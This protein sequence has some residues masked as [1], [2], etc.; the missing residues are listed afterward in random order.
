MRYDRNGVKGFEAQSLEVAPQAE[1]FEA[2]TFA[3]V[4]V[5]GG[6]SILLS[7]EV[8]TLMK[9]EKQKAI[10]ITPGLNYDCEYYL[11]KKD[12]WEEALEAVEHALDCQLSDNGFVGCK[13]E[14]ECVE[15]SQDMIEELFED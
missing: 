5:L 3:K 13:L 2:K 7:R 8:K 4:L 10:K 9:K 12:T 15:L 14:I 6:L 11:M 1:T